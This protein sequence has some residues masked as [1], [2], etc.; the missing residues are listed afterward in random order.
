MHKISIKKRMNNARVYLGLF[1]SLVSVFPS[2]VFPVNADSLQQKNVLLLHADNPLLPANIM[3]DHNFN[4]ILKLT[5]PR[6]VALYSEY[7]EMVRFRSEGIEKKTLDLLKEK[8]STLKLDLI[9]VTDD[10]SWDYM[11]AHGKDVFP[12][13]PIVFCGIT[14]GIID[15]N[16]L[17]PNVTG[18]FKRLD[19][20][21]N[22]EN[23]LHIQPN[24]K[25]IYVIVGTSEQDAFYEAF[26][27]NVAAEFEKNI[28]I[29]FIKGLS[30]EDTQ[31]KI[32]NLPRSTAVFYIAMYKDGTGKTFN[33][34]DALYLL[35]KAANVPI[36]APSDT[37]LGYG[38][39]GGN[40]LS[41]ADF[42][43]NAAEIALQ[44]LNGKNPADIPAVVS[45][46]KNYFDFKEMQRWGIH[47]KNLPQGSIIINK[48]PGPWELY[49][50]QV[51]SVISIGVSGFVLILFLI[52]QIRLKRKA[53]AEVLEVNA[54]LE[55]SNRM[56]EADIAERMRTEKSLAENESRLRTLLQ[57]I[58]D[59]IWLKDVD[60]VYRFCNPMAERFFGARETDIVGKSDYDL[61]GRELADFFRMHDRKAIAAGKPTANEEW[62]TFADDGYRGL[63]DTIKTP[64]RNAEGKLIGILG[65]AHDITARKQAEE[66]HKKLE[67]Q[68]RQAQKMEA[69]GRL[70]G[71]VAHDF[72]NMLSIIIGYAELALNSIDPSAPLHANIHE[73]TKAAQRSADLTRQL[74]A[75]ARKQTIAPKV[76]DLNDTIAGM[77]KMLRR[78]IGEDIDLLW[79]PGGNLWSVNMDPSQLDQILANLTVNAR[80]AI[81]GVGKIT[82]ETGNAEFEKDYCETHAGFI[83]GH[84]VL[85]AF[86]D[87]GCGM[88]KEILSQ[89]F[90]PFF[91]TK[92]LA[93]GTGLGLSTVYGIV[94][95]N[96]GFINVYSEPGKGTTFKF[97]LPRHESEQVLADETHPAGKVPTGTET[98][99]L[100]EDEASLL[101][102]ARILLEKLGYTVLAAGSPNLAI[103]L[104]MEYTGE[105][106]LLMTDVVMPEMSGRDLRHRLDA[107][108][109]NLKCLFMSGYTANAIAHHGVLDEGLHFL[110]KPF[111]RE[112]L[113]AKLRE[114]LND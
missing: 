101:E 11:I 99:L 19:V 83:P 73:I 17:K 21:N 44:V 79:K 109:P 89:L 107:L 30:I 1:I 75:F 3:M 87:D 56:L 72:N 90:E 36:Y 95:Q 13:A 102:L 113:A 77:L 108:L 39:V 23:I 27:R 93:K 111:S 112:T 26:A 31:K 28:K 88:D 68:F 97:Y 104:V 34:R 105:I 85:V 100:V 24:T 20:K 41:F 62:L 53:R 48:Q 106:H 114:A 61:V 66:A 59:L 4:S 40:L 25:E 5:N 54:E 84:Y 65:I 80:D 37:Y 50:W 52:F 12:E 81:S 96:H 18:N 38:M 71:G 51:I 98:V 58:P 33:P 94:K 82:I 32:S 6:P 43:R 69:V 35:N 57:T 74:L 64:M 22:F 103:Q 86:S 55:K 15:V 14:A 2:L 78:L 42:S 91:T 8:Y 9:I 29:T 49:R 47:E 46:N 10:Q 92:P 76:L 110:Q 60:G 67:A 16:T 70:A 7:L 63:F 45:P